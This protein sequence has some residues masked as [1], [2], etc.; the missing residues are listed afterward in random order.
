[1]TPLPIAI[2]N[3]HGSLGVPPELVERVALTPAQ[4]FNEADAYAADLY[5]FGDRVAQ[6]E[7]FPYARTIIDVNRSADTDPN[8][9]VGDGA[10]KGR[11]SYGVPVYAPG[12]EPD[13]DLQRVLIDKYWRPWQDKL[14]AIA[15][16]P[17][18]KLV[19][20]AH[21]MA[22]VGPSAFSDPDALR[23]R[24]QVGNHGDSQGEQLPGERP[25]TAQPD[26][27]RALMG[28]L[29][30]RLG[31]LDPLTA[32]GEDA[33]LN[34]PFMGGYQLET[35]GGHTQP[36][37]MIEVNR[38]LY[39]GAQDGDTPVSPPNIAQIEAVRERLWD[40]IAAT[41]AQLA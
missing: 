35:H 23:P 11:T 18:I 14:A 8:G 1:M 16:N 25:P 40:A 5:N 34:W 27:A 17:D 32:V 26:L 6:F 28:A 12:D 36:W 2:I 4:I 31:D 41:Y 39:V 30:S 10:I 29:R 7:T 9:R 19:I 37:L 24:V 13:A 21:T 33:T 15:R 3:P 20:D 22:A 38:A